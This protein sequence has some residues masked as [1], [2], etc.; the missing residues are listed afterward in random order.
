MTFSSTLS[1]LP[2]TLTRFGI[3]P[4]FLPINVLGIAGEISRG[5]D[6][7]MLDKLLLEFA[8]TQLNVQG[9]IADT[10]RLEDMN[11][12]LALSG[13]SLA[14]LLPPE[15]DSVPEGAFKVTAAIG[16]DD[17]A[18]R[19]N[20]LHA[21]LAEAVI[22]LD[23]GTSLSNPVETG[24]VRFDASGTSIFALAPMAAGYLDQD[25]TFSARGSGEWRSDTATL[26]DVAVQVGQAVLELDGTI[27]LPPVAGASQLTFESQ[28]N[29]VRNL[30]FLTNQPLPDM[31][32]VL[33]G[34][35][36]GN[37]DRLEIFLQ[38]FALGR[39]D[40]TGT[41][42]L[43]PDSDE[44]PV[45]GVALN[46]R[47][48]L[49]DLV[50]LQEFIERPDEVSV[51]D[52]QSASNRVI[53]DT[54][55]PNDLMTGVQADVDVQ[56]GHLLVSSHDLT[57]VA[58]VGSIADGALEIEHFG[59]TGLSGTLNGS[60]QLTPGESGLDTRL[61]IDGTDLILGLPAKT[62]EE[63]QML[64]RY[65]ATV[66]LASN[67]AT[68]REH[69]SSTTGYV[70]IVSGRGQLNLAAVGFLT[71]DFAA[72]VF[73]TVNPFAKKETYSTVRCMAVLVEAVDGV[74][75]GDPA[76]VFRT[77]K[78]NIASVGRVDLATEKLN[79]TISTRARSGLGIS[80]SDIVSPYT[81]LGGT[82]ASPRLQ[83]NSKSALFRGSATIAT[84]GLSFLIR[85]A[86]ERLL[87]DKNPCRS[88]ILEAEEDIRNRLQHL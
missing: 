16:F 10:F 81:E 40:L 13:A 36:T 14:A 44:R 1:D 45:P 32:L 35:L 33:R 49:I 21:Q 84:G 25:Q 7:F 60:L 39:T 30:Q 51:P 67:G 80:M 76:L 27:A 2:T 55:I 20:D 82:L 65:D 62:Q 17:N 61:R 52:D 34:R 29:S 53:P 68:A 43:E 22:N 87:G 12:D 64:P 48:K 31:P 57:D 19:I 47:S 58:L 37:P 63:K 59:L 6:A 50:S 23:L 5:S 78:L 77:D 70:K 66:R 74:V 9:R 18:I 11:F 73:N 79:A 15:I 71:R 88:A 75:F 42:V 26:T 56:A 3:E 69:A 72:E 85:K 83:L 54:A 46:L 86:G 41:I 4:E 28:L 8:D 38:E 24:T